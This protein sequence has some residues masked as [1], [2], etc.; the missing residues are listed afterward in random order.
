MLYTNTMLI[1]FTATY[2]R[3]IL[4]KPRPEDKKSWGRVGPLHDTLGGGQKRKS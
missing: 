2:L 1:E 4:L 3:I